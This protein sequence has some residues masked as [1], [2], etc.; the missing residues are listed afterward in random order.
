MGALTRLRLTDFRNYVALNLHLSGRHVCLYGSNGSGKTN[1]LEAVSQLGPG[2]GL[3]SAPL[4]DL[5]RTGAPAG[6]TLSG[7]ID[8]RRIGVGLDTSGNTAKR[9][10]RIDGENASPGDLAELVRIVWLTPAMDGVFRGGAGDRRR[11]YDRQVMA[12]MPAHGSAA[13]RYEKA[14]RE[15]NALLERAYVDPAWADALEARLAE[16][17]AEL[18]MGRALVLSR[19]QAAVDNRP[20]GAFPKADLALNG[21]AEAMALEGAGPA[22]IE[23]HLR[24]LWSSMRHADRKA[25]RTLKGPHRSD[26]AV[27]H[28]PTAMP[29]RDASTGQQKALLIGLI[30]ASAHALDAGGTGPA[31][32]LLLDEA[33]AHLD[34]DRRAALFDELSELQGQAWLT[35]TEAFLFDAFGERA[36]RFDVSDGAVTPASS[37]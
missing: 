6:W 2:R 26:L 13:A 1:L 30:L 31:P 19:L 3:R 32:F 16:A 18:A 9:V 35:G 22:E 8:D 37:D 36:E 7:E 24:D 28:R 5:T 11:F 4:S 23:A 34:A 29:A 25:G 12:H 15:R 17:G 20:E 27:M 14:M 33:A 21:D 10:V